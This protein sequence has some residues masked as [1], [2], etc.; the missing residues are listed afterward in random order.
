MLALSPVTA[1]LVSAKWQ[2]SVEKRGLDQDE[3]LILRIAQ[4][5]HGIYILE[6]QN[7]TKKQTKFSLQ[8]LK[9]NFLGV[10]VVA[11]QVKNPTG[12]VSVVAQQKRIQLGTMR[13]WV[14][15]LALFSGSRIQHC[16]KL[17]C[18]SQTRLRSCIAVAVA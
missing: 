2:L 11:Q 1:K 13:L 17:W 8:Q 9:N 5:Q 16:R 10:P 6:K 12:K 4:E 18:R 14:R 7:K 3:K 15:Y